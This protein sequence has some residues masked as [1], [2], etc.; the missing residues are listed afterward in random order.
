MG[1]RIYIVED[2]RDTCDMLAQWL[3]YCAGVEICGTA[4]SGEEALA[5][6][7]TID[8]DLVLIDISLPRMSGIDFLREAK[9]RWPDLPCLMLSA[10]SAAMYGERVVSLGASGYVTKGDVDRLVE[11]V[12]RVL[13]GETYLPDA[14]R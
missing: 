2:D 9:T 4:A 8:A 6:L 12:P 13:G 5:Q 1:A 10:H 11:A 14:Q 7:E 3:M